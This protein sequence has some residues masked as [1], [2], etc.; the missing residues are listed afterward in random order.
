MTEEKRWPHSPDPQ[1]DVVLDARGLRAM[2]HPVRVQLVGLL[3]RLGPSTA[4]RLAERMG[5]TSGATSYHL[6]QLAAA[7][8]VT[9]D[10]ERGNARER[11]WK[12]VHQNTVWSDRDLAEQEPEAAIGFL[13]SVVAA[14]A[15][16]TQRA[17]NGFD[18][19]S[20]SWRHA[21]EFSDWALR[22]TPEESRELGEELAAVV[23][24]YRRDDAREEAPEGAERVA[25]VLQVLPDP[26]GGLPAEDTDEAGRDDSG[27]GGG[28]R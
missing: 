5:L 26:A 2:A 17:L 16:T 12:A 14:N 3:R 10:T 6:R 4:T 27:E 1:T 11:W 28:Q 25:V 23:A 22:L 15:L 24:R 8:F 20:R 7:G 9:E 13:R 21:F 18:A 19:M